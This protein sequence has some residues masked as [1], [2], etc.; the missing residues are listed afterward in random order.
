MHPK[1]NPVGVAES[2]AAVAHCRYCREPFKP[3]STGGK[4]QKF[5]SEEHRLKWTKSVRCSIDEWIEFGVIVYDRLRGYTNVNPTLIMTSQN[6]RQ[7]ML[8]DKNVFNTAQITGAFLRSRRKAVPNL[9][10]LIGASLKFPNAKVSLGYSGDFSLAPW[11][12]VLT[13]ARSRP[14]AFTVPL[15]RSASA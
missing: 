5:C 7:V 11:I 9:G 14:S 10:G 1:N 12:E 8:Y 15:P 6:G 3:R 13:S 4:A 2:N